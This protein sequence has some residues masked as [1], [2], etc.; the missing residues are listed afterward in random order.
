MCKHKRNESCYAAGSPA[1]GHFCVPL[2]LTQA[3]VVVGD[4]EQ[5]LGAEMLR[6]GLDNADLGMGD[7]RAKRTALAF[8]VNVSF[9]L[10]GWVG[11]SGCSRTLLWQ[12]PWPGRFP[13]D[14]SRGKIVPE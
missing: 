3:G 12:W 5:L 13:P 14:R 9:S 1:A 2:E 10:G 8:S 7:G 4:E 11:G 6:V